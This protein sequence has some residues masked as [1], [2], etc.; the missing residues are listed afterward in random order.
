MQAWT[1]RE[2]GIC[3]LLSTI[4]VL[5]KPSE[6]HYT[7]IY[8]TANL[9]IC[10]LIST[11]ALRQSQQLSTLT[12]ETVMVNTVLTWQDLESSQRQICRHVWEDCL[13]QVN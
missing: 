8:S 10:T 6:T 11:L 9:Q 13:G 2:S 4:N 12:Y 3:Q 7:I 1:E 5:E